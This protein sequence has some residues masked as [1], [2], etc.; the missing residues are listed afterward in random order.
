MSYRD[1]FDDISLTGR[2]TPP[3]DDTPQ[4][5][6]GSGQTEPDDYELKFCPIHGTMTNHK[7]GACMKT[8]DTPGDHGAET[9]EQALRSRIADIEIQVGDQ[10]FNFK[11]T[12]KIVDAIMADVRRYS[13]HQTEQVLER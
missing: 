6:S 8:P 1:N 12:P 5:P 7:N 10:Y 3:Q 2:W 11:D 4:S 13:H 9:D